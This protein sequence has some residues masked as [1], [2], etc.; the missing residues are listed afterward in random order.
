MN[1]NNYKNKNVYKYVCPCCGNTKLSWWEEEV[2]EKRY[3]LDK[4]GNLLKCYKK[5]L[6]D[7]GGFGLYCESCMSYC[8]LGSGFSN[9]TNAKWLNKD[10]IINVAK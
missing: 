6:E 7:T 4:D 5:L 8:N 1:K 3:R 10:Y 2:I 9:E